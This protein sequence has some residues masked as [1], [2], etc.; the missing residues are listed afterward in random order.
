MS[1]ATGAPASARLCDAV[2]LA[3]ALWTL[4]VH[5][6]LAAG[7]SLR[8]LLI[9]Y[10]VLGGAALIAWATWR[11]RG[12][13]P[14]AIAVAEEEPPPRSRALRALRWLLLALGLAVTAAFHLRGNVAA[15]WF[16]STALLALAAVAFVLLER[17]FVEAPVR[18]AGLEAGL[19]A[20]ALGCGALALAVNRPDIDDAFYVNLALTAADLP[21]A[22]LLRG[23]SLHG[24]DL[25]LMLPVYRV[26]SYE[27][28][29]GALS[30][31]SGRPAIEVFHFASAALAG[32]LVPLAY[33]RAFRWLAPREWLWATLAVVFVLLAA[34]ETHRWYGNFAFV[35]I[36]QGKGIYLFVFLPLIYA[37][38]V[39]FAL[40]PSAPRW[41]RLAAAQIAAVG[42]TSSALWSA[43]AAALM[44][45]ACVLRPTRAGLR[46]FAG[47]A[48]ASLYVLA[49]A[50]I[51]KQGLEG[52]GYG[53]SPNR[54]W[55][56]GAQLEQALVVVFGG[57]RLLAFS[58]AALLCAW[59]FC[60]RGLGQRFAV[61]LPFA[62]TAVLLDPFT[63][64]FV[65][66]NVTS[67]SYWRTTWA[68]PV[69]M[70]MALMLIA[71][72]QLGRGRVSRSAALTATA[73]ALAGFAAFVPRFSALS[74]ENQGPNADALEIG[75]PR[76][77]V[78]ESA[79]RWA[80]LVNANVAPGAPVIAPPDVAVWVP[81]YHHH[82]HPL[83]VRDS[84]LRLFRE[85]LGTQEVER[86]HR[87]S[88]IASGEKQRESDVR[89]LGRALERYG[90]RAVL[91]RRG[92]RISELREVLR[93]A[94]FTQGV[95]DLGHELWVRQ[96][97]S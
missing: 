92:V 57:E 22:P 36:W 16:A 47:G 95:R 68:L 51:L 66:Q 12:G 8:K 73:A 17:P 94:G 31:L 70:L 44:T 77:K 64:R 53:P 60:R 21:D 6:V 75:W 27:L 37:Y 41:L 5:A 54:N 30:W 39:E 87:L 9:L 74:P 65:I 7:G 28:W 40:R 19:W 4:C 15:L 78:Q 80:G 56:F 69:P 79:W 26:H 52:G 3:F 42:C 46:T 59:V 38:A 1:R 29:N 84:Y 13:R 88:L 82:A 96:E 81:T 61:L 14:A 67:A 58:V 62:V 90:I 10:A 86:R 11:L 76:L 34:G 20:L 25:P 93:E 71:P 89:F 32:A 45:L 72:L 48:L 43:P 91:L 55:S 2:C 23:D 18:G 63:V 97:T 35:R 50:W 33:A 83:L 24:L 85:Q 49:L